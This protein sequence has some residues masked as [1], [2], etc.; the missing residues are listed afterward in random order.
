MTNPV[1]AALGAPSSVIGMELGHVTTTGC[2]EGRA[3]LGAKTPVWTL[4]P[5][6]ARSKELSPIMSLTATMT[7]MT[8][9]MMIHPRS[10]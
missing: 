3:G 6:C 2:V 7:M 1:G 10:E 8:M 4:W 5:V 9:M